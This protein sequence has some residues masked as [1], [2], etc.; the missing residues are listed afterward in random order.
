MITKF[1]PKPANRPL[2]K[3][4]HWGSDMAKGVQNGGGN[5]TRFSVLFCCRLSPSKKHIN[6]NCRPFC[7]YMANS[8]YEFFQ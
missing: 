4:R 8:K 3:T 2:G 5:E 1:A 7:A 6:M